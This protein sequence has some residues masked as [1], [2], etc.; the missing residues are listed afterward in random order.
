MMSPSTT[1]AAEPALLPV[2]D[3]MA[4]AS[5]AIDEEIEGEEKARR[6]DYEVA[7]RHCEEAFKDLLLGDADK[8][9]KHREKVAPLAQ[10]IAAT[11]RFT[12]DLPVRQGKVWA[13][14]WQLPPAVREILNRALMTGFLERQGCHE[15]GT[16]SVRIGGLIMV[17]DF[18]SLHSD[19]EKEG[20]TPVEIRKAEEAA[21]SLG[22]LLRLKQKA[23]EDGDVQAAP[24][25]STQL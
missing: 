18:I 19:M 20:L 2:E 8:P 24:A 17:H 15:A 22:Q 14:A 4:A 6:H 3:L 21:E 16:T 9:V 11:Q 7:L 1:T 12:P 10:L 13:P 23:L 5:A 25:A